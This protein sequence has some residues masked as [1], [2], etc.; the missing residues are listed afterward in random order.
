MR[1]VGVTAYESFNIVV[2]NGADVNVGAVLKARELKH[3][4]SS[5]L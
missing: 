2:E 5:K 4:T 3:E 1:Y